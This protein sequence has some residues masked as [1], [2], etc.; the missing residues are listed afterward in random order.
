MSIPNLEQFP[1]CYPYTNEFGAVFSDRRDG[2]AHHLDELYLICRKLLTNM[3]QDPN[4][5]NLEIAELLLKVM[6]RYDPSRG[7]PIQ[8]YLK[9]RL[10]H[11]IRDT[12]SKA[13]KY[14][15]LSDGTPLPVVEVELDENKVEIDE[16]DLTDSK[17]V[18]YSILRAVRRELGQ[19]AESIAKMTYLG[20]STEQISSR[21]GISV[22]TIS[23]DKTL[24][25]EYIGGL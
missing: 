20:H 15:F 24:I 9:I 5:W 1:S 12:F 6:T 14:V 25:R 19:R 22:R 23:R 18:L 10:F 2:S 3:R 21:T 13:K 7:L 8:L 16:K 11:K 4:H 17:S